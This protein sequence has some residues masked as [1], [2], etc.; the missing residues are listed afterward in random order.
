MTGPL[1]VTALEAAHLC[2]YTTG[3]VI[4][5]LYRRGVFPPPITPELNPRQWR[6]SRAQVE[7][8]VNGTWQAA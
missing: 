2:G 8:Y 4:R 7:A 5:T 6:W 1:V 3:T